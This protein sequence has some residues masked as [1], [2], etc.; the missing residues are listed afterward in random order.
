MTRL[1]RFKSLALFLR[2]SSYLFTLS[3]ISAFIAGIDPLATSILM[4]FGVGLQ[5]YLYEDIE[6]FQSVSLKN[7]SKHLLLLMFLLLIYNQLNL[8]QPQNNQ[9]LIQAITNR[10]IL[11]RITIG[12][13]LSI[14]TPLAEELFF[15]GEIN[16]FLDPFRLNPYLQMGVVASLFALSHGA[17]HPIDFLVYLTLGLVFD[18]ASKQSLTDAILTHGLYNA[19]SLIFIWMVEF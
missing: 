9:T 16:R 7:I 17:R 10:P 12:F 14:I 15:R 3:A 1:N 11:A 6:R 8:P 18:H 13:I 2:F 19:I 4:L 5:L